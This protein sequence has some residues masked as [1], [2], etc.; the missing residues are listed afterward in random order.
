MFSPLL[1]AGCVAASGRRKSVDA[2]LFTLV[3][4]GNSPIYKIVDKSLGVTVFT[5]NLKKATAW[6]AAR[7]IKL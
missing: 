1:Y 2:G 3:P 6:L 7:G 4:V 5:G